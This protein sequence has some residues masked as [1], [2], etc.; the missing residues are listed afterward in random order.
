MLFLLI[1]IN[2]RG[3][4]IFLLQTEEEA[5]KFIKEVTKE[6]LCKFAGVEFF[7]TYIGYDEEVDSII[8]SIDS[9][10]KKLNDKKSQRSSVF[11]RN[12]YG[13]EERCVSTG[14]AANGRENKTLLS[15]ESL[16]KRKWS[17]GDFLKELK[18]EKVPYSIETLMS[19]YIKE[20]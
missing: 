8:D 15:R 13:I 7:M 19:K 17:E 1:G 5:K 14:L 4:S 6:V 9:L 3:N 18:S 10:Y 12:S 20:G 16:I 11:K 2:R